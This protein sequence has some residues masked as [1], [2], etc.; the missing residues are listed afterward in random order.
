MAEVLVLR[1]GGLLRPISEYGV[2]TGFPNLVS[3]AFK[4]VKEGLVTIF[5]DLAHK[6]KYCRNR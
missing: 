3:L 1:L 6:Y 4:F 5:I 2:D